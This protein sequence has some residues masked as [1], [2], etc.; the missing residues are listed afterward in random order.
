MGFFFSQLELK[1]FRGDTVLIKGKKKHDT[2]CVAI[3]DENTAD[4]KILMN[5]VVRRNLRVRL[6]DVITVTNPGEVPYGK[7]I[8]VLPF[9]DSVQGISGNLFETY[10]KP[11]F[12][13]AYRP[14]RKG[15]VC[16]C[17]LKIEYRKRP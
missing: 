9:D 12:L 7:A 3:A 6:G 4:G 17:E 14:V 16:V 15:T 2:V 11:Y 5:K 8:H 1:L 13:E 10:L